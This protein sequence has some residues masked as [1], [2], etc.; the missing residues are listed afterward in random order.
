MRYRGT[1][2]RAARPRGT[3][4][5]RW[6]RLGALPPMGGNRKGGYG[7]KPLSGEGRLRRETVEGFS[8]F[9]S[10]HA[11]AERERRPLLQ[12]EVIVDR[13]RRVIGEALLLVNAAASRRRCDAGRR[14]LI[15]DAPADVLG[16]RLPAI[17][18]PRILIRAAI[19]VAEDIHPA[20]LVEHLREPDALARQKAGVLLVRAPVL[21]IDFLVSDVPVAAQHDLTS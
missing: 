15:I 3:A 8:L 21:E 1:A 13:Q 17:G 14:D 12:R 11:R 2:P 10:G 6:S 19:D 16:P 7:G 20:E 18:P 4:G 5:Q 9:V